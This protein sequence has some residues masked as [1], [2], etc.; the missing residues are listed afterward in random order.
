MLGGKH[1]K[2]S[3]ECL[4]KELSSSFRNHDL[5]VQAIA[6]HYH[7]AAMHPFL[8]GNGR[9]SRA[10]EA[11]MM[12][13]ASLKDVHFIPM[14]NYYH[15]NKDTYLSSL[16][17]VRERRHDLTPFLKF[18]LR[19]VETQAS[20]LAIELGRTVK[21]ELFR[22]FMSK[23]FVRL[24]STRKR[25]IVRRQLT[26]LNYLL[27]QDCATDLQMISAS[28]DHLYATLKDPFGAM[29]RDLNRLI[30]LGAIQLEYQGEDGVPSILVGVNL[31]WPSTLTDTEFF[32][33]LKQLPKSTTYGSL[34]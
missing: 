34:M 13:R 24:E 16:A 19:G 33:R 26:L 32:E 10:T 8:D 6:T 2:E 9:T 30:A 27:R 20:R 17:R 18:A 29:V 22:I 1:C 25:V 5:L 12:Q 31:D 7:L 28:V 15:D 4:V 11:L 21:K 23:L 14:S 3:L